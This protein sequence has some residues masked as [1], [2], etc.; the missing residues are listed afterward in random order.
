MSTI[1][2]DLQINFSAQASD[3]PFAL[4]VANDP[5][6]EPVNIY[7]VVVTDWRRP[8]Q[9]FL[10]RYYE[11]LQ[12]RALVQVAPGKKRVRLYC[13]DALAGEARLL[14]Y[15]IEEQP[16][17][18]GRRF[19]PVIETLNWNNSRIGRLRYP[20]D[21]PETEILDKT[22]FVDKENNPVSQPVRVQNQGKFRH[23]QEV[24]GTLVVRYS[25]A[26]SLYEIPYDTG[27]AYVSASLLREM[28]FAWLAGN[29]NDAPTPA[30]WIVAM[31]CGQSA[32]ISFQRDY[33][34]NGSTTRKGY[35]P[36]EKEPELEKVEDDKYKV[37]AYVPDPCWA[38]CHKLLFPDKMFLTNSEKMAIADCV[39]SG[40]DPK[41]QYVE[42]SRKTRTERIASDTNPEVYVDV[43]RAVEVVLTL[44]RVD[45]SPCNAPNAPTGSPELK[46]RFTS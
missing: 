26:F 27:E 32:R 34:P 40:K 7:P 3:E 25:P 37:P 38:A 8:S 13:S 5:G 16:S 21:S 9:D 36:P 31:A 46:F 23:D 33:W 22:G 10:E 12:D 4:E 2:T 24:T 43:K 44:Q 39:R 11:G 14:A 28:K 17:Y 6:S 30:V 45:G 15:N 35:R 41:Y 19:E 1:S 42:T 20:Y 18:I 29:I